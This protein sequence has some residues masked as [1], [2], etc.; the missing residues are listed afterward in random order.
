MAPR[1][2]QHERKAE[3]RAE[4]LDAAARSF[5]RD[6]YQGASLDQVAER[7][8]F[9]TGAIYRHFTSKEDLFLSLFEDRI[10]KRI[11]Q[12]AE[13]IRPELSPEDQVAQAAK[14]FAELSGRDPDW[15]L[16]LFEYWLQA[17]RNPALR[18][19]FEKVHRGAQASVAS[20]CEETAIALGRPLRMPPDQLAVALIAVSYGFALERILGSDLVSDELIT[21]VLSGIA[22]EGGLGDQGSQ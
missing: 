17:A 20:L 10:E 6:G 22:L 9:T 21:R 8:G 12:I 11:L 19:R 15:Y 18:G 2:R 16:L 5:A 4:L 1:K 7:A 13:T 3:T 14:Q